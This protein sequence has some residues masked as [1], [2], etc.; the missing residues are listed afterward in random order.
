MALPVELFVLGLVLHTEL[1]HYDKKSG[2]DMDFEQFSDA[3]PL[4]TKKD[5]PS[6]KSQ[7]SQAICLRRQRTVHFWKRLRIA[8]H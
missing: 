5:L 8:S 2:R 1:A 6:A 4:C 3:S 7:V